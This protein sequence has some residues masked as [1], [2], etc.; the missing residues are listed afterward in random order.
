MT[1]M[2]KRILETMLSEKSQ[3]SIVYVKYDTIFVKLKKEQN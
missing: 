1:A 3:I 2:Y